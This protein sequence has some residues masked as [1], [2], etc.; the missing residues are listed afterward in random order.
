MVNKKLNAVIG[1]QLLLQNCRACS[2]IVAVQ[3][4]CVG[5][6]DANTYHAPSLLYLAAAKLTYGTC[7]LF[8]A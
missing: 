3:A 7:D 8:I 5:R 1:E 4:D 2:L 6:I